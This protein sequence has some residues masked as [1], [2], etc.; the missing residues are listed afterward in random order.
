MAEL[1]CPFP[2]P[3]VEM[4]AQVVSKE[5]DWYTFATYLGAPLH[6]LDHIRRNLNNELNLPRFYIEVYKCRDSFRKR[7]L[8]WEHIATSLK[9]MGN[10]TLAEHIELKFVK[11]FKQ[12]IQ[13][14]TSSGDREF[15]IRDERFEQ[16]AQNYLELSEKLIILSCKV[17]LALKNSEDV[18]INELQELV[19]D[20]CG[21]SL[22]PEFANSEA[23]VKFDETFENLK[24][25]CSFLNFRALIFIAK[26]FLENSGLYTGLVDLDKKI[27]D[28][29]KSSARLKDYADLIKKIEH[30]TS[31]DSSNKTYVLKLGE[32]WEQFTIMQFE[33]VVRDILQTL[34][35]VTSQMLV[36]KGCI[37]V[38]GFFPNH[39]DATELIRSNPEESKFAKEIGVSKLHIENPS[40]AENGPPVEIKIYHFENPVKY[41]TVAEALSQCTHP[42]AKKH[43]EDIGMQ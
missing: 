6:Q 5:S 41:R 29:F 2:T 36:R 4:F 34:H 1:D 15:Q 38:N 19:K 35:N 17:K 21:Y 25:S 11:P 12:C 32:F 39:I 9:Q 30:E 22:S 10:K 26:R 43:L 18:D 42:R 13:A 27:N 37:C 24:K 23:A 20:K 8:T 31:I 28:E 7:P 33:K 14:T 3:P 16:I 40:T